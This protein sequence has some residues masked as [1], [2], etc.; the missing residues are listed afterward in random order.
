MHMLYVLKHNF[1]FLGKVTD[2]WNEILGRLL[3][4]YLNM[5]SK[6][7]L[8]VLKGKVKQ[9]KECVL[10]EK[11]NKK[12]AKQN[13]ANCP[14]ME[15][16]FSDQ[17]IA[18]EASH[19]RLKASCLPGP[20]S[21]TSYNKVVLHFLFVL[22]GMRYQKTKTKKSLSAILHQ[23]V[24]HCNRMVYPELASRRT[25]DMISES[26]K[27][28]KEEDANQVLLGNHHEHE[29]Q[30]EDQPVIQVRNL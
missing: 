26:H 16:L 4:R 21:L 27:S 8:K 28:G 20:E 15:E 11:V 30:P 25:Y 6:E 7:Y 13:L 12:K 14:R 9:R 23:K 19:L 24:V 2:E 1:L 5:R 29:S 18:M 10:R 3:R 22:Y 17:S